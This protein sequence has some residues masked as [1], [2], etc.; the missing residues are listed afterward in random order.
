M[1]TITKP[2]LLT[3]ADLLRLH[4]QGIKGELIRGELRATVATDLRHGEIAAAMGAILL[5][6]VR[7]RRLG[8]VF[9]SDAGVLLERNPDTVREPDVAYVSAERLPPDAAISGYCPVVPD[10]VVEIVSPS[11]GPA[12]ADNKAAMW[13]RYGARAALVLNPETLAISIRRPARPAVI[14]TIDDTL[15]LDDIL[16]GF[17]CPVRDIL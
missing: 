1:T 8:R 11:D 16:P 12:A 5:A 10:L 13:L 15:E 7:P 2:Q 14:L 3:A 6:Y 17:A 9:G 4:G